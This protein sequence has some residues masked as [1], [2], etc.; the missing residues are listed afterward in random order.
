VV[1]AAAV[2]AGAALLAGCGSPAPSA[3]PASIVCDEGLGSVT[4]ATGNASGVYAVMGDG[5]AKLVNV[6][7]KLKAISQ[8]TAA[9]VQNIQEVVKGQA[10]IG[11]ASLDIAADAVQGTG[12]FSSGRQH[13]QALARLYLNYTQVLVRAD[14]GIQDISDMRGKRI[15]TGSPKSG[16]EVVAQRLLRVAGLDPAKDV[17]VQ[18]LDI[19]PATQALREGKIDGLFWAGGLPTPAI[20]DVTKAMGAAVRMVPTGI[21]EDR[22]RNFSGAYTIGVMRTGTYGLAMDVPALVVPNVLV[23]RDDFPAGRA[24]VLTKLLFARKADLV[25][26]HPAAGELQLY[27][28]AST[29]PV[30]LAP[31]SRRALNDLGDI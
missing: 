20:Q 17:A 25:A 11:F 12:A 2:V 10:D 24:C 4:I 19:G 8:Q 9:S 22:M 1:L 13:I 23:V 31:G 3:D 18:S 16:V 21:Y 6:S 14:S 15:S 30:P 27:T 29:D 28:A 26:V 5:L 7:T